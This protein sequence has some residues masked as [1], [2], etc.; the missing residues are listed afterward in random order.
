VPLLRGAVEAFGAIAAV[1]RWEAR[2]AA[3]SLA[4]APRRVSWADLAADRTSWGHDPAG[5]GERV[6]PTTVTPTIL[7]ELESLS[8]VGAAGVPVIPAIAA[9]ATLAAVAAAREL[10]GPVAIKLDAFGL[11]HKSDAG[12]LRLGVVGDVAVAAAADELLELGPTLTGGE[13]T[14][15]GLLVEPMAGP[16]LELIIGLSR[17]PGFGPLVMVGFGGVLA[18]VLDDVAVRLAP[19]HVDEAMAMLDSL[20]G[21]RL[22]DGL[23]GRPAA[24]RAA[25]A[26]II[27]AV[28]QIGLDRPDIA[29]I[30][31]NPVISGPTG[32]VAVDALVVM[33]G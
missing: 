23:R 13:V 33:A 31:L 8:L 3:R 1:A 17:D 28:G 9:S 20:R 11:A 2:Q 7:P 12:A 14:V 30:D 16:G 21:A 19:V 15:R 18:E 10:G 6:E 25:I 27:V 29:A 22:L 32:T 4:P 5:W 26:E 24:D